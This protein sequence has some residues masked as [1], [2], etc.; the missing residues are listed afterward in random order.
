MRWGL[1]PFSI[2]A[3]CY[4]STRRNIIFDVLVPW[5]R[6]P[7]TSGQSR[8]PWPVRESSV[9]S[10]PCTAPSTEQPPRLAP[11]AAWEPVAWAPQRQPLQDGSRR[12]QRYPR[13]K[14]GENSR[15][16]VLLLSTSYRVSKGSARPGLGY[17][18]TKSS[19]TGGS[20]NTVYIKV[21]QPRT[22]DIWN[23]IILWGRGGGVG[24]VLCP[25]GR[26]AAPLLLLQPLEASSAHPHPQARSSKMSLEI[27]KWP[28]GDKTTFLRTTGLDKAAHLPQR[29]KNRSEFG[30]VITAKLP[31]STAMR[32][33]EVRG[34]GTRGGKGDPPGKSKAGIPE[35]LSLEKTL[36][37]MVL[38]SVVRRISQ[39][40]ESPPFWNL[41]GK[42]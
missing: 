6:D 10:Q 5:K 32:D 11:A 38:A 24:A 40:S 12:R 8:L 39:K 31:L 36:P 42:T 34:H 22:T 2:L 17:G 25:A 20:N 41:P 3:P 9:L 33:R 28:L 7:N 27:S 13:S 21:S 26:L 14:P 15:T 35:K 37:Q 29:V 23:Q 19:G 4:P 18:L 30:T 1:L 16:P